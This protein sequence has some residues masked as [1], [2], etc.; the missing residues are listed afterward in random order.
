MRIT[1]GEKTTFNQDGKVGGGAFGHVTIIH[2]AAIV[3][4]RN[5]G[6]ELIRVVAHRLLAEEI[7]L[8]AS[9]LLEGVLY[10]GVW[11]G[12]L[13]LDIELG[14]TMGLLPVFLDSQRVIKLLVVVG[15]IE[16]V[17]CWLR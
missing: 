17:I 16:L 7:G 12:D 8:V 5:S 9:I 14:S 4:R 11:K 2:V 1:D 3:T 15:Q 6:K 13:W 10:V